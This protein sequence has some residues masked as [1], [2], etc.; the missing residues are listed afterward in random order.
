MV[1]QIPVDL[2]VNRRKDALRQLLRLGLPFSITKKRMLLFLNLSIV[3]SGKK[4]ILD[5]D[6]RQCQLQC[7]LYTCPANMSS[8][9]W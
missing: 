6:L 8:M 3:S 4:E 7:T 2:V 5:T 9:Y 1:K